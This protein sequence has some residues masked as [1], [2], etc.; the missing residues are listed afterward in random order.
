MKPEEVSQLER[1]LKKRFDLP[2]IVVRQTPRIAN[3]AE[4]YIGDEM[5][6]ELLRDEDE[7]EISYYFEMTFHID[8]EEQ[9]QLQNYLNKRF[10]METIEV[11]K[12]PQKEDSDEVY[13]GDEFVAVLYRENTGNKLCC[14]FEMS[15]LDF[16][17]A[18][19]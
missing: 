9:G 6:A 7:G 1:F 19:I 3:T 10:T 18:E 5:I 15:I 13:I 4:V 16:D 8:P 12:R 11:R 14:H 2:A 17:L